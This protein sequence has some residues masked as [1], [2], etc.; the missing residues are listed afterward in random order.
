MSLKKVKY[1]K[2][3]L[4]TGFVNGG[5]CDT[6]SLPKARTVYH[7]TLGAQIIEFVFSSFEFPG[8]ILAFS[9]ASVCFQVIVRSLE[10]DFSGC[11]F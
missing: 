11:P 10:L 1:A 6:G 9:K 7:E 2:K 4:F 3:V 8:E 5:N